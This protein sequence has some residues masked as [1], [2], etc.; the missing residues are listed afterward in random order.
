M[1]TELALINKFRGL[2][3]ELAHLI[4]LFTGKFII[5]ING[6]LKSIINVDD[7]QNIQTHLLIQQY[8]LDKYLFQWFTMNQ[9]IRFIQSLY[10]GRLLEPEERVK[11]EVLSIQNVEFEKQSFL[12]TKPSEM[13]E[14]MIPD[15][16][17]LKTFCNECCFKRLLTKNPK[18]KP[19]ESSLPI[20]QSPIGVFVNFNFG[21]HAVYY[22]FNNIKIYIKKFGIK[23]KVS[24]DTCVGCNNPLLPTKTKSFQEKKHKTPVVHRVKKP[25]V[26]KNFRR[27]N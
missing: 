6:K 22:N 17:D 27:L 24:C 1:S 16:V 14:V 15:K 11:E 10:S 7:F 4:C 25:K 3:T 20:R 13:E 9:K 23:R 5:D 26:I 8:H 12:F 18:K 19:E 21:Y 2:P